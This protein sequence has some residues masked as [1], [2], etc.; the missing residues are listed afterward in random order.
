M[1]SA[2]RAGAFSDARNSSTRGS[3][4]KWPTVGL[5]CEAMPRMV[6]ASAAAFARRSA[7]GSA[8]F[9]FTAFPNGAFLPW[10]SRK[11]CAVSM[12]QRLFSSASSLVSPQAV[13]P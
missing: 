8:A 6:G 11:A 5:S 3:S 4:E 9:F 1:P 10:V 12:I 2:A 7:S 13:M